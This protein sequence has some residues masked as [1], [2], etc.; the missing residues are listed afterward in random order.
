MLY[1][2]Q[3]NLIDIG[4]NQYIISNDSRTRG[5]HRFYQ[6][7]TSNDIYGNSFV[8]RTIRD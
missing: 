1:E 8:H 4:R 5:Q 6:E 7:R 2:I 3:K